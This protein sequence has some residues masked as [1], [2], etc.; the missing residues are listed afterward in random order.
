[1]SNRIVVLGDSIAWGAFDEECGGWVER[2]KVHLFNKD[3]DTRVYNCGVSADNLAGVLKRVDNEVEARNR[4]LEKA[5]I[6]IGINDS[7]NPENPSGT[8]IE[9]FQKQ[10]LKLL[11]KLKIHKLQVFLVGLTNVDEQVDPNYKNEEIKKYNDVVRK[12]AD[13]QDL[14]FLNI[15]G[16]L[17]YKDFADGLHPNASGHKKIFENVLQFLEK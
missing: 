1:M 6:A 13:E 2:L 3:R 4:R 14:P 17:E 9:D 16:L 10:Y 11:E 8:L 7:P 15:F 12:I 5:V